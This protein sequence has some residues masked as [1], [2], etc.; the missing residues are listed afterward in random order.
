MIKTKVEINQLWKCPKCNRQFERHN[1]AHSCRSYPLELHFER[2]ETSRK[3]YKI[4]C[5]KIKENLG[6]YKI[7]S[8]E[9]CI[10]LV[11]TFTFAAVKILK[12]KI[13]IDFA[14]NRIIKNKRLVQSIKMSEHRFLYC[15]EIAKEEEIDNELMTWIKEAYAK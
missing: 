11:N 12:H 9:C 13:K 8:L 4:L 15:V 2:K 10:H 14:L 1:Q 7:E 3:L 5:E 6:L